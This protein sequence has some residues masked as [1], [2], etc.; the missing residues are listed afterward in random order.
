MVKSNE[1]LFSCIYL[2]TNIL[3]GYDVW[4]GNMRGNTYGLRHVNKSI[5]PKTNEFWDF[6][7]VI[8]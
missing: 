8:S 6:R 1:Y 3:A 7:F 5:T 4:L 2:H